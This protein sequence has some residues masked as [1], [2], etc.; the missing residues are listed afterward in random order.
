[1]ARGVS[2]G[3]AKIMKCPDGSSSQPRQGATNHRPGKIIG[4]NNPA[5][6]LSFSCHFQ[7]RGRHNL[8]VTAEVSS[9]PCAFGVG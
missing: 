9:A 8:C 4:L 7:G 6:L 5:C 1:M 2:G 3:G